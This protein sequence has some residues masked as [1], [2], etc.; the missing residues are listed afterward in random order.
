MTR[1]GVWLLG[2][3]LGNLLFLYLPI[4]V[5]VV[6]S[7]N[8]SRFSAVWQGFSLRWYRALASDDALMAA[9]QN[10]LIVGVCATAIATVLGV[11][12]AVCMERLAV[13]GKRL[14]EGALVLPLVIPEIMMGVALML[15]FVIIKFPLGLATITIGH[16]AMNV[17][18][19]MII[20]RARLRKLDPGLEEA[21]RDLGATPWQAFSRVTL[22]LLVPAILG[23]VLMAFTISLD[24]FIVAFFTAG[25]GSTTLPL[26]VYS[27]VKSSVSPAINALSAVLVAVSMVLISISLRLQRT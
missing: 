20:I 19:V 14:I 10:S 7:F 23:A 1:R 8:D 22:P 16:I 26:R 27:M 4:A 5:L 2:A 3:S 6:F 24:D 13:R 18:V 17:P 11:S 15:F 12:A 25:P 21:A 9:L